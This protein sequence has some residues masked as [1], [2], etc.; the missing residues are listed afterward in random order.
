MEA[1]AF[2]VGA[3]ENATLNDASYPRF[4]DVMTSQGYDWEAIKVTTDDHYILTTFHILGK[5]DGST[6]A[7]TEGSV[8]IQHGLFEDGTSWLEDYANLNEKSFQ[9]QLVDAGYDVWIGSNRGTEYSWEHETLS[10]DD[11]AYWEF[12]WAEM[13]M[14]DDPANIA[15]IKKATG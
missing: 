12:T 2:A 3:A 13:G 15:A 14:Y 6:K 10:V 7:A 8:L 1:T 9:L 5:T 11:G 4:A